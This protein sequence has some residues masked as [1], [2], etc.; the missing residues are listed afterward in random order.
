MTYDLSRSDYETLHIPMNARV[1]SDKAWGRVV[2]DF[3]RRMELLARRTGRKPDR[4]ERT[5]AMESAGLA[6]GMKYL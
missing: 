3:N 1:L 6:N 4:F 2:R 5:W